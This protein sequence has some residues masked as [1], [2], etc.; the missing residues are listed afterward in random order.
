MMHVTFVR[1]LIGRLY[2][3]TSRILLISLKVEFM[4]NKIKL[5]QVFSDNLEFFIKSSFRNKNTSCCGMNHSTLKH[6]AIHGLS[7]R[8][9]DLSPLG[10][11]PSSN[12]QVIKNGVFWDITPCGSCKNGRSEE[13]SASFIRVTRI[14]ELGTTSALTSNRHT[15][16]RNTK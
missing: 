3:A 14:G 8:Y 6:R 13:L 5:V 2:T 15:L 1:M 9:V 7:M 12:K 16:R 10:N 4:V 11:K